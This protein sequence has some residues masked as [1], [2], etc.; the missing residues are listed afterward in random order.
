MKRK[1]LNL[2]TLICLVV[3]L[4]LSVGVAYGRYQWEFPHQSYMFTPE[5]PDNLFL[6][7]SIPGG[8]LD[9]GNLPELRDENV[10]LVI[11]ERNYVTPEAGGYFCNPCSALYGEMFHGVS[12][13]GQ[14]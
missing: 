5:L 4:S 10:L 8:W 14:R 1:Y 13:N 12:P 11:G 2:L 6:C 7:G 3:C 9:H